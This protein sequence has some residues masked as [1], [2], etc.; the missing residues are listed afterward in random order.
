V[1]LGLV[2]EDAAL[3]NNAIVLEQ[4]PQI[5]GIN[6]LLLNP[7]LL[8]EDFIFYFDRIAALLVER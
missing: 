5:I 3:S 2:A 6:T 4:K 1:R 7:T 8:R